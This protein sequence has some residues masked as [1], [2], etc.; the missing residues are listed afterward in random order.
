MSPTT[1]SSEGI[2]PLPMAYSLRSKPRRR[3][4]AT[5][6]MS[7]GQSRQRCAIR[8]QTA[9]P[10]CTAGTQQPKNRSAG[11]GWLRRAE[12]GG[13]GS[14][15]RPPCHPSFA[16]YG[17]EQLLDLLRG[18]VDLDVHLVTGPAPADRRHLGGVRYHRDR[19]TVVGRCRRSSGSRRRRQSS[20]FRRSNGSARR[21]PDLQIRR[22]R[23]SLP[24]W[25]RHGPARRGPPRRSLARTG[26]SRFTGSPGCSRPKVVRLRVSAVI[27]VSKI[28]DVQGDDGH[29]ATVHRDRIAD[30]GALQDA[31]TPDPVAVA[32]VAEVGAHLFNRD[33]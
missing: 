5:T 15:R 28:S 22:R 6:E 25:R 10:R 3:P 1:A 30:L 16:R 13:V 27:S 24:R 14:S 17:P 23:P 33:P 19:E 7:I 26:R 4:R 18:D 32:V 21:D 29:T 31:A 2:V 12:T 20:P 11:L 9:R 8:C